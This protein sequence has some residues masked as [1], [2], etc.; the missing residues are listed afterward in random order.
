MLKTEEQK[1][2][3]APW[4]G[5]YRFWWAAITILRSVT[6]IKQAMG[7][8]NTFYRNPSSLLNNRSVAD[9]VTSECGVALLFDQH[10]NRPGH[11]P[12][13]SRQGC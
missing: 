8:I 1:E 3:F 11:V 7:R 12:G 10:V 2:N 9:Y 5:A 13:T 4:N 6:Q